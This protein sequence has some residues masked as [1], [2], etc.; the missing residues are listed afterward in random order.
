MYPTDRKY[1]QQH[2]WVKPED[3][4]AKVGITHYAQ[5][6]LGDIVY[7]DL[8]EV[9]SALGQAQKLGEVESVKSVSELYSPVSGKVIEVNQ[10]VIGHPELVNFDPY[11][12]GWLVRIKPSNPTEMDDLMT[13]S[14]Y[15][16]FLESLGR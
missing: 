15:E 11:Q 12:R 1:S 13:A 5:D 7:V 16:S 14:D 4:T 6:Q 2:E 8:P 3:S 10:E 9:G